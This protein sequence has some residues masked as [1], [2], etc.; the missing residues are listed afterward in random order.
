MASW[1]GLATEPPPQ[2]SD[3][4]QF[5]LAFRRATLEKDWQKLEDLTSF[6]LTIRGEL[7]R[8]PIRRVSRR[9]FPKIFDRF[10]KQG[11]FSPNEQL[12]FIRNTTTIDTAVDSGGIC[13]IGDM[14]FKKA[15]A[16]WRLDTLYMQSSLD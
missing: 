2:R 6:P 5:W 16:G 1:Q 4:K 13:R 7:D 10:L 8:D 15:A 3:L 14:I 12:E 9:D 11:V